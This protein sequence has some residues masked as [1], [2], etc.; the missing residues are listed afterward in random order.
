[1][2]LSAVLYWIGTYCNV[3]ATLVFSRYVCQ[4]FERKSVALFS[5]KC[6]SVQLF[7]LCIPPPPPPDLL[8]SLDFGLEVS[9]LDV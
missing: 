2:I 1:M 6:I 8:R 7:P 3:P 5:A 9:L 4:G